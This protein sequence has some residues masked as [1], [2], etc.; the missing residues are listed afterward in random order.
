MSSFFA[1]VMMM[2][3]AIA[4]SSIEGISTPKTALE[5]VL[6]QSLREN[7]VNEKDIPKLV[8]EIL[9]ETRK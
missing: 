8:R 4:S 9:N 7:G 2:E 1:R 5:L 3:E 6:E